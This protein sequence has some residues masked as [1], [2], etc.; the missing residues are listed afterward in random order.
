MQVSAVVCPVSI[1]SRPSLHLRAQ[2]GE[3]I[4]YFSTSDK[5]VFLNYFKAPIA[6]LDWLS[7]WV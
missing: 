4:P 1:A 6:A 2:N 7:S 3:S 5:M